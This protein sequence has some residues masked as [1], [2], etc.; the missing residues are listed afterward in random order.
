MHT[1]LVALTH[2]GVNSNCY[3]DLGTEADVHSGI[4]CILLFSVPG[5]IPLRLP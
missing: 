5:S 1:G 3:T 4:E 2:H